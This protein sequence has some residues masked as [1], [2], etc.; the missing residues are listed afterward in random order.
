LIPTLF[1]GYGIAIMWSSLKGADA[2][3]RLRL[4]AG[5]MP[6]H[7]WTIIGAALIGSAFSDVFIVAAQML[8]VGHWQPW[9]ISIFSSGMLLVI[10]VLSLSM[11]LDATA[12][13]YP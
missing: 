3:P 8:G 7:I 9:I 12:E 5:E 2:L 11:D 1:V 6:G 10:G 4:G 13:R